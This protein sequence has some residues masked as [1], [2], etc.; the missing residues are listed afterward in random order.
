[1][2]HFLLEDLK[3]SDK[4]KNLGVGGKIMS[5]WILQKYGRNL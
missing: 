2:K 3:E 4:L 1:M 5:E